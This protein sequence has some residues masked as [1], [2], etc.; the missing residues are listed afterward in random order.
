MRIVK[1]LKSSISCSLDVRPDAHCVLNGSNLGRETSIF[2]L[3]AVLRYF[4]GIPNFGHRLDFFSE[5]SID[6]LLVGGAH[7]RS[8]II[9]TRIAENECIV[10]VLH[11]Y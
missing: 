4:S 1:Q 7:R 6:K 9:P 11:L 3:L 5:R 8:I 2:S 10:V